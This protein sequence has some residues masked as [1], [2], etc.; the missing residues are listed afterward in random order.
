MLQSSFNGSESDKERGHNCE[1]ISF[2]Y[3]MFQIFKT[4]LNTL[5][6]EIRQEKYFHSYDPPP[7]NSLIHRMTIGTIHINVSGLKRKSEAFQTLRVF[8]HEEHFQALKM[9]NLIRGPKFRREGGSEEVGQKAQVCG[10]FFEA[11]PYRSLKTT[12]IYK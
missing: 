4:V 11:F 7:G 10:F 5:K 1:N 8:T 12:L 3:F 9:C 6:H 2:S